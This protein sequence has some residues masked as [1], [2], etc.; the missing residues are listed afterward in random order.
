LIFIKA[1]H[2]EWIGQVCQANLGRLNSINSPAGKTR[3]ME[4]APLGRETPN[5]SGS[6]P[7]MD[8]K[9][10]SR[11]GGILLSDGISLIAAGKAMDTA[12][13]FHAT[14]GA[15]DAKTMDGVYQG[16]VDQL[17]K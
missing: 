4:Q 16:G 15:A 14:L 11:L 3:L 6:I 5:E 2:R 10:R 13:A 9:R 12:F 7:E 8:V 17:V 1:G